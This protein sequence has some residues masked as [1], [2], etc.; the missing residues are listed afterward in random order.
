MGESPRLKADFSWHSSV[1]PGSA[2]DKMRLAPDTRPGRIAASPMQ[3]QPQ[4]SMMAGVE[5]R[6]PDGDVAPGFSHRWPSTRSRVAD[7][8]QTQRQRMRSRSH[9][10][11]CDRQLGRGQPQTAPQETPERRGFNQR[12]R[13][14]RSKQSMGPARVTPYH[15]R[16]GGDVV[17]LLWF[18]VVAPATRLV[19]WKVLVEIDSGVI[20]NLQAA[21]AVFRNR[22]HLEA[23]RARVLNLTGETNR[24]CAWQPTASPQMLFPTW[25]H[26]PMQ[27]RHAALARDAPKPRCSPVRETSRH[28]AARRWRWHALRLETR[29]CA[30]ALARGRHGPASCRRTEPRETGSLIPAG[31]AKGR[32]LSSYLPGTDTRQKLRLG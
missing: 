18:M 4:W 1:N 11:S 2:L 9:P 25:C 14:I 31:T 16:R 24:C 21:L 13:N 30:Q 3:R 5:L 27:E 29:G 6:K 28:A 7:R 10:L 12:P 32:K 17:L 8:C 20:H 23:L 26:K 15:K 22:R 19:R